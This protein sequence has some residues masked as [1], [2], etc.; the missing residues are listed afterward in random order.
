MI[1]AQRVAGALR[2][3][4]HWPYRKKNIRK[5]IEQTNFMLLKLKQINLQ[6]KILKRNQLHKSAHIYLIEFIGYIFDCFRSSAGTFF[7]L[8]CIIKTF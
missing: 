4:C 8:I 6:K 7:L 2:I 3:Q 5:K 1:L